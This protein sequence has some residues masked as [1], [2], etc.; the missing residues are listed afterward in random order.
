[1]REVSQLAGNFSHK[2]GTF[3]LLARRLLLSG[4]SASQLALLFTKNA[5]HHNHCSHLTSFCS[6][7]CN[8]ISHCSITWGCIDNFNQT[9]FSRQ[10]DGTS[11]LIYFKTLVYAKARVIVPSSLFTLGI[12]TGVIVT[13]LELLRLTSFLS[14]N[15]DQKHGLHKGHAFNAPR[16]FVGLLGISGLTCYCCRKGFTIAVIAKAFQDFVVLVRTAV[17]FATLVKLLTATFLGDSTSQSP[18]H[19]PPGITLGF[20][21]G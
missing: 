15:K 21:M 18:R 6:F 1:M 17:G 11:W 19:F 16:R 2:I 12:V 14:L 10:I 4:I 5:H 7:N 13:L 3:C 8:F 20:R 9:D